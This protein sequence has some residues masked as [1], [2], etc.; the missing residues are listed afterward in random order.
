MNLQCN[1]A[2][3]WI[4]SAR[5]AARQ[6]AAVLLTLCFSALALAAEPTVVQPTFHSS[7]K[8][9]SD[10]A[11][12]DQS[13]VLL[14]FGAEWCG[15]CQLLKSRTLTSPDFLKQDRPLHIA[16]VDIDANKQMAKDFN[17]EAVPTLILL[18]PDGKIIQRHTGF[19]EAMALAQWLLNGRSLAAAGQWE[20]TAPGAE[21]NQYIKKA[22][23]DNL[24]AEDLTNLVDLL[25]N[26]NPANREQAGKL[27]MA[28]RERVMPLLIRAV[29]NSYLG[30]R[31]SAS[32]LL[33][34]LDPDINPIDPWRSPAEMSNTVVVLRKWWAK[35]G[36]LPVKMT[37]QSTNVVM[38]NSIR[39]ALLQLRN[40]DPVR[41]TA[42]M[43]TLVGCGKAALPAVRNAI[44]HAES[45]ND[46]RTLNLLEDVHW[47]ILVPDT[48]EQQSGGIRHVLAR[49]KSSERQAA[50]E[51]LGHFG[52]GALDALTE[53][54]NDSD[55][56]VVESAVRALSN[57]GGSDTISALAALLNAADNNLRMT[58]AQ[59]LGHTKAVAAVKPLLTVINDPD[60]VV[61]CTALSALE[62][63]ESGD[64]YWPGQNALPKN[65]ADGLKS[66]LSD[67]RW[68]VRAAAAE[69]AGKLK[70]DA[71]ADDL[72]KLLDD[73]DGFVVSKA[74][75]ALSQLQ[76]TPKPAR[77]V[78]LSK[79]LP[80]LQ[81][82]TL[83]M[84]L[85]SD[86]DETVK[87][88]TR[89]YDSGGTDTQ[90]AILAAMAQRDYSNGSKTDEKWKPLLTEAVTGTDPRLRRG[91]AQ[92]LGQCSP[93]LAA[94]LVT[95]L[96]E[97]A[98]PKTRLVAAKVVLRILDRDSQGLLSTMGLSASSSSTTNKP[99]ITPAQL[100]T[101]HSLMLKHAGSATNLN[102]ATAIYMTGDGKSDLP[103]LLGALGNA[104]VGP[105]EGHEAQLENRIV[106]ELIMSKLPWPEGRPV[107]DKLVTMPACYAMAA[108][109]SGRS[110]AKAA[111]YLLAPARFKAALEP[112]AGST[113]SEA[114]E[115]LA[116]YNYEYDNNNHREWSLWTES[117]R[118]KAVA[119]ALVNST[120]A[121]W[122]A[123]AVFSLGLRA[124]ARS[125]QAVFEQALG[126]P[127][128]WVRDSAVRAIFRST[129]DHSALETNLA[130]MLADT[131]LSVAAAAAVALL[132]P[133]TR[134]AAG[135]DNELATFEYKTV[136]GGRSESSSQS[137]DRPLRPLPT[138][139]AFLQ[140]ARKWL[141]RTNGEA[142]EPF[143]L[144]LAQYGEFD[145]VDQLVKQAGSTD[146][147]NQQGASD[148]LLA[149]IA[150]SR[151]IKYLPVLKQMAA[152][153]RNEWD[154][155]KVLQA[156]RGMSG[157]EARQ[158]RLD[159]NK[160]IRNSGGAS[161]GPVF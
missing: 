137:N 117:D 161:S 95:P 149:G 63:I 20:G 125:D 38:A 92:V 156:M 48:I 74:L 65:I 35:T 25:G 119:L 87:T 140:T 106:F 104:K 143:A 138:K 153:R 43:T 45:N 6:V 36:Q 113:L 52:R 90:L 77:L 85:K 134:Q 41:R 76:S 49:G 133:E 39:E 22:A 13:L 127:N 67:P 128:P 154:L 66:C 69:V 160:K 108:S 75:A 94:E 26:A 53:L 126:D 157:P 96:L 84:I 60:E 103:M 58:A 131:N 50:A 147:Q 159:I 27:L 62:E 145:G 101:W 47:T 31:I 82:D 80:S 98:D 44:K 18:T 70:A 152:V 10:A 73:S 139:P 136:R 68:R 51:R 28:Q 9:A 148:V 56:L 124:D 141:A 123:A 54:A 89:L 2:R 99:S 142:A 129:K 151:N 107:L 71:L 37:S 132:E 23:A 105:E 11:A 114:L 1:I 79:R 93:K 46:Q 72:K 32:E 21:L 12:S 19:M 88:V 14:I 121:G 15:P 29:G 57:Y 55:P 118:T 30:I 83:A 61:A 155:R 78:A 135:L 158:L 5:L 8:A 34:Q 116:G 109:Q 144:L 111:D 110:Q 91:A 59:A 7:F 97:D 112:A 120:N 24:S 146:L 17:I 115:L 81:A 64:S 4:R 130:P 40:G 86:S 33:R 150:L 100:A 42:A 122:R 16:E 102:L 3:L